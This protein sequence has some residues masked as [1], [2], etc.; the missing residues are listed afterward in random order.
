[1]FPGSDLTIEVP[2][3]R[4]EVLLLG[5]VP[6]VQLFMGFSVEFLPE[7]SS[8]ASS[9]V[10][11]MDAPEGIRLILCIK[12]DESHAVYAKIQLLE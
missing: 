9:W 5:T 6:D 3:R 1:M 2:A 12:N 8:L 7:D 4:Q 11:Y 10:S